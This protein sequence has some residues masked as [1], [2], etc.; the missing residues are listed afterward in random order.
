MRSTPDARPAVA[1]IA[2][3]LLSAGAY[4]QV[5]TSISGTVYDATQAVVPGAVITLANVDRNT[6]GTRTANHVGRFLFSNLVPGRYRLEV[7]AAGFA[8]KVMSG[9]VLTTEQKLDLDIVLELGATKQD[10]EVSAEAAALDT[11]T[12]TVGQV[13]DNR[14]IANLPLVSR[15]S[16][17]LIA[18]V[19]NVRVGL[20]FDPDNFN[21]VG[22]FSINGGRT[23]GAEV[24]VDGTPA[25]AGLAGWYAPAYKPSLD[26]VQEFRVMTNTLPAE[27]GLT[28]GGAVRIVSKSGTNKAHGSAYDYLRNSKLDA[29]SFFNN[30]S[31]IPLGSFRR[32]QFGGT[33]GGPVLLPK[34][35]DGKNRTFFFVT[36]E[37]NRSSTASLVI[38]SVPTDLQ[39]QGDFSG[40]RNSTGQ[41][42]IIY[43][44]LTT[45][46]N[47]AGSGYTRT[48]FAGNRIPTARIDP[49]ARNIM[50]YWPH[51]NTP[52]LAFTGVQNLVLGSASTF[53][54]D[55]AD[56]RVDHRFNDRHSVYGKFSHHRDE[57]TP[58]RP[59]G[60]GD[61][62][63][64]RMVPSRH[65]VL[66]YT[67]VKSN[68]T[69]INLHYG[70]SLNG[71][72]AVGYNGGPGFDQKA[73]GFPAG[74]LHTT[75][76]RGLP[77]FS[78]T[79]I[80]GVGGDYTWSS[81]YKIHQYSGSISQV[82]GRHTA[83]AGGDLRRYLYYGYTSSQP[84][85]SFSFNR[86]YTQGADPLRASTTAGIGFASFLLGTGSGSGS[87]RPQRESR[88]PVL[89]GYLQDDWKATRRLNLSL[90]VRYDVFIP[91]VDPRNQMSWFD[92]TARNPLSDKTRLDLRGGLRFAGLDG[93]RRQFKTDWNN[94]APRVGFAYSAASNMTVRGGFAV[95]YP[96]SRTSTG[97]TQDGFT[98]TTTWV[99]AVD[100]LKPASFLQNAFAGGMIQ[101]TGGTNG[102]ATLVGQSISPAD[103][104]SLNAYNMQWNFT[105]QREFPGNSFVEISYLGNRGLHLPIGEGYQIN[106]L[107]PEALSL[108]SSLLDRV[109]N[110]FYGLIASGILSG[111][112]TTRG[113]LLRPFPQFGSINM[114][115]RTLADSIYHALGLRFEKRFRNQLIIQA[116]YTNSKLIDDSSVTTTW[117]GTYETIQNFYNLR[118]E[119]SLSSQDISQSFVA[120]F[121][122]PLPFGKGQP[123]LASANRVL[124]AVAGGWQF[125]GIVTMQTGYPLGLYAPNS[126]GALGGGQRPNSTGKSAGL[127]GDV[128]K[129]LSRYFD[130]AQ[131]TQPAPYTFGNVSRTLADVRAGGARNMAMSLFKNFRL[132]EGC[133]LQARAE[134]SN[135][136]NTV[137]FAA[138]GTTL[139]SPTFGVISG[140]ANGP[141]QVQVALRLEF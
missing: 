57:S 26:N 21:G 39:K 19:P 72:S 33:F 28:D 137:R 113:Q 50:K 84:P 95:L 42:V 120:S 62:A 15:Q 8:P 58:P 115:R 68:A 114:D 66:D 56:Y 4:A 91:G 128:R 3:L 117:A 31:G 11:A 81:P 99:S 74:F 133:R 6:A 116:S 140:Q 48:P 53:N 14:Q 49:V 37:G 73:L 17:S 59:F 45:A 55:Q 16:L 43:D 32:N 5:S 10:V 46:A 36:Y 78:I 90:G 101:P 105:V 136:T 1:A 138:P 87:I 121:Q 22:I 82:R 132:A 83:K 103:P 79:D 93:R 69:V 86:T 38:R 44:P 94:F 97:Y 89:S 35:Y 139:G 96:L 111:P 7:T 85:A 126:T 123:W 25:M 135:L 88:A 119:R 131:F 76:Y 71:D 41:P 40:N 141:R 52:G 27:F 12:P 75:P 107:S 124:D 125:N 98:A 64:V 122:A 34:I 104:N 18:L 65:A 108:G 13:V 127:T 92:A 9:I 29:N 51:P 70:Y 100:G 102:L 112:T 129:R 134:T 67:W 106:Q 118:S 77:Q 61:P 24:S 23:A 47:P 130:T 30:R 109:A 63:Y 80:S 20:G 60:Y 2:A 54:A 110:P